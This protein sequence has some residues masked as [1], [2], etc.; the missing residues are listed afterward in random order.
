MAQAVEFGMAGAAS[1]VDNVMTELQITRLASESRM[2]F[3][4]FHKSIESAKRY[5][6]EG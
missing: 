3:A 4:G 6:R 2:P 5:L 1:V